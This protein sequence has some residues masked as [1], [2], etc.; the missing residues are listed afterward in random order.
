MG[1]ENRTCAHCGVKNDSEICPDCFIAGHRG[2]RCDEY[3]GPDARGKLMLEV[4]RTYHRG[5]FDIV[6]LQPHERRRDG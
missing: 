6:E 3:C 1:E 2:V 5:G 4:L